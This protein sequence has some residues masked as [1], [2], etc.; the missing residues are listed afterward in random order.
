MAKRT[1]AT[2]MSAPIGGFRDGGGVS[3]PGYIEFTGPVRT[4]MISGVFVLASTNMFTHDIR[5]AMI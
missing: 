3:V 5:A 2:Y 1:G 4:G